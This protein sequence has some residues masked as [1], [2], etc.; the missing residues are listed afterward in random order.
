[1]E[2]NFPFQRNRIINTQFGKLR[3]AIA[4]NPP[5]PKRVHK[6]TAKPKAV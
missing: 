6:Q 4:K 1:M 3:K 5:K 2:R